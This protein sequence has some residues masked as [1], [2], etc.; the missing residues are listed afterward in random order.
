MGLF[1]IFSSKKNNND[2][3]GL[4]KLSKLQQLL[5]R[6]EI[7]EALISSAHGTTQTSF[8]IANDANK[9]VA[10]VNSLSNLTK[11][12]GIELIEAIIS[13]KHQKQIIKIIEEQE[14]QEEQDFTDNDNGWIDILI[15]WANDSNLEQLNIVGEPSCPYTGF[16]RD[17]KKVIHL[18]FL[19]LTNSKISYLPPELGM[20]K[21]LNHIYLDGNNIET[22][23]KELCF[24]PNLI[25]LD[26]DGNNITTL[27]RE[28]GN[29]TS[30]QILSLENN[31]INDLPIEMTKLSNLRKLVLRGQAIHLGSRYSPLSKEGFEVRNYFYD[32]IQEEPVQTWLDK[33]DTST[34]T[35]TG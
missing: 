27:P 16:P 29:L 17:R 23:P 6:K 4:Q 10:L 13:N 22:I 5:K 2:S 28:I 24:L 9:A 30:L 26:I 3:V 19:H 18:E 35:I 34:L 1:D 8:S 25:R 12:S 20:L 21:K 7:A 32:I 11:I 14:L 33:T 15:K 31:S